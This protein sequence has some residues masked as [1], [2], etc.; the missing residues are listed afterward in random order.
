[1]KQKGQSAIKRNYNILI[2]EGYL[3]TID[4]WAR[5]QID[6]IKNYIVIL[7]IKNYFQT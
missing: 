6:Y 3:L 2:E 7:Q 1:M 5:L 4:L